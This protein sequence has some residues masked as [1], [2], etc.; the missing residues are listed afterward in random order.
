MLTIQGVRFRNEILIVELSDERMLEV[1]LKRFPRLYQVSSKK[2]EA[3]LINDDKI[4]WTDIDQD[5]SL[6]S[7]LDVS[8]GKPIRSNLEKFLIPEDRI[9]SKTIFYFYVTVAS[10]RP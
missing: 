5:I 10:L 2:R 7:I 8:D 4:R 3:F 6:D 9:S 1:P